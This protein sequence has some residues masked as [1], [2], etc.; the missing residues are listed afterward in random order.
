M[1]INLNILIKNL[2]LICSETKLV[3]AVSELCFQSKIAEFRFPCSV[4]K[5]PMRWSLLLPLKI[6]DGACGEKSGL[7]AKV[8]SW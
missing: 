6:G 4:L 5:A 2:L 8:W 3:A 1:V 7:V